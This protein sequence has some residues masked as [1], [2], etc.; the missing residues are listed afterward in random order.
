MIVLGFDT[1]T[2]ATVVALLDGAGPDGG[3]ELRHDPREGERPGHGRSLL[4]LA[5]ALLERSGLTF[6]GVDRVA[7]GLGPGGFTGLRIGVSTARALAQGAGAGL[8]GVSTLHALAAAAEPDDRKGVMAVA[9]ARRGK[10][11]VAG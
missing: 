5:H 9:D 8:V 4:A 10:V 3:D 1:A 2:S 7:V 6:A 11:F